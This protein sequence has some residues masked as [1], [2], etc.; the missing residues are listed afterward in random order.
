M[1]HSDVEQ[2]HRDEYAAMMRSVK[3]EPRQAPIYEDPLLTESRAVSEIMFMEKARSIAIAN[4]CTVRSRGD[5]GKFMRNEMITRRISDQPRARGPA[6]IPPVV[7]STQPTP[8]AMPTVSNVATPAVTHA[9]TPLSQPTP[10]RIACHDNRSRIEEKLA[11]GLTLASPVSNKRGEMQPTIQTKCPAGHVHSVRTDYVLEYGLNTCH[12]C[13]CTDPG[14]NEIRKWLETVTETP[15]TLGANGVIEST[16]AR[17]HIVPVDSAA[18]CGIRRVNKHVYIDLVVGDSAVYRLA[19][20]LVKIVHR[21]ADGRDIR[22]L[23]RGNM[24]SQESA[25]LWTPGGQ[26]TM[27]SLGSQQTTHPLRSVSDLPALASPE[28]FSGVRLTPS[29]GSIFSD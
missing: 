18:E 20:R 1:Q 29:I 15:F 5:L 17:M 22:R 28:I 21:L 10:E 19:R 11:G 27:G 3:L 16:K 8:I 4:G 25:A 13:K 14:T 2:F 6:Y 7:A 23:V 24:P 26:S 12:T 9:V